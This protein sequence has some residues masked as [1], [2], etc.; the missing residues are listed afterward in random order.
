[1]RWGFGQ[2]N[3]PKL[4]LFSV[5]ATWSRSNLAPTAQNQ[6]SDLINLQTNV[7]LPIDIDRWL[8]FAQAEKLIYPISTKF[9]LETSVGVTR[10]FSKLNTLGLRNSLIQFSESKLYVLSALNGPFN[11][12]TGGGT[13][14]V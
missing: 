4:Y 10:Q 2:A 13:C 14:G 3:W 8:A 12:E 1:M 11:V 7:L 5:G 9:R 6:V